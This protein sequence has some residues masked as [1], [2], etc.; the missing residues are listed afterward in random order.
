ME[1]AGLMVKTKVRSRYIALVTI[2]VTENMVVDGNRIAYQAA[3]TC[4]GWLYFQM[5]H[6][7]VREAHH[8]FMHVM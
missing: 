3:V 5:V 6:T 8:A 4:C 2:E 7:L 1:V